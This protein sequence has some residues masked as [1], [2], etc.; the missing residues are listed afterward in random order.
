[1]QIMPAT[2]VQLGVRN[3][4]DVRENIDGGVRHLRG[5]V[6][7]FGGDLRLA[8]AAYNAGADAVTRY[9]GVPPYAETQAY[10]ARVLELLRRTASPAPTEAAEAA[11]LVEAAAQ[12]AAAEARAIHRYE[13]ADGGTIYSNAAPD[14]LSGQA[15]ALLE[16]R[17]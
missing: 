12:R 6:D 4:F 16:G 11:G 3:I 10:V 7:R 5:L 17:R 2:A 14:R 8:L 13:T 1:M 15:R 9:G